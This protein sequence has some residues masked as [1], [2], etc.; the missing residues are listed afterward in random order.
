MSTRDELKKERKDR[1]EI[2][3]KIRKKKMNDDKSGFT[4][5]AVAERLGISPKNYEY[6]E[7]QGQGMDSV[8]NL[9]CLAKI[10]EVP[11]EDLVYVKQEEDRPLI[12]LYR[13]QGKNF[14]LPTLLKINKITLAFMEKLISQS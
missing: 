2:I 12:T 8:Y 9:K 14:D 5:E 3:K 1:G 6:W 4:Q 10:L 11:I 13:K 7:S